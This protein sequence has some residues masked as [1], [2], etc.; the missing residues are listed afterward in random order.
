[1][2]ENQYGI[3]IFKTS[4]YTSSINGQM[5]PIGAEL[6]CCTKAENTHNSFEDVLHRPICKYNYSIHSTTNMIPF[7]AFFGR[8]V[9]TDPPLIEKD[10]ETGNGPSVP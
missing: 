10:R 8:K 9:Y 2:L 7:E 3:E 1:M 4:P 6:L 5:E